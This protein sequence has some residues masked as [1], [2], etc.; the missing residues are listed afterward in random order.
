MKFKREEQSRKAI[1]MIQLHPSTF[2][3]RDEEMLRSMGPV[4]VFRFRRQKG[5]GV[6][7][8]LIREK[9]F[10]LRNIWTCRLIYV[11]FADFHTVLPVIFAR[12]TGKKC[13]VVIGGVDAAYL[14]E[15]Q[16][17]TKTRILGRISLLLTVRLA[18]VLLPVSRFTLE[19]LK[20]NVSARLA[21]KSIVVHNCY[22]P[23]L[24]ISAAQG[25]RELVLTIALASSKRTLFIKGVDVFLGAAALMD[26][27]K[28]MVVGLSGEA[29][30][31]AQEMAPANVELHR[32]VAFEELQEI[33]SRTRVI[34]QFS[35]QESFGIALLEGL[36]AGCVPVIANR[37]GPAEVFEGSGIPV[38]DQMDADRAAQAISAA[39]SMDP[40]KL[41]AIQ[42]KVLPTFDCSLRQKKLHA[43]IHNL[44]R[45]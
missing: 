40:E 31:A 36:A 23:A 42:K 8:E 34:C 45:Q 41:S 21:A 25:E 6:L 20:R 32:P 3:R 5:I 9:I 37:C 11:W 35:R 4:K 26:R 43:V 17:G 16:Y 44:I 10:L 38:I 2:V 1:L 14:P 29:L 30:E 24:I 39:M 18:H 19:D 27:Y 15:Y 12:L 13:V 28:F 7:T 33:Y 22:T